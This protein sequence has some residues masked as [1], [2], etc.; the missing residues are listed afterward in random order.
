MRIHD[1]VVAAD[2]ERD[3]PGLRNLEQ[4]GLR[5]RDLMVCYQTLETFSVGTNAYDYANYPQSHERRQRGRRMVG[6]PVAD[7]YSRE[8]GQIA[9][10]N[11]AAFELGAAAL[12]DACEAIGRGDRTA[13]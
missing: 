13:P 12:L 6:H 7:E 4:M 9:E 1:G 5:G 10:V 8:I 2:D 3:R 11:D